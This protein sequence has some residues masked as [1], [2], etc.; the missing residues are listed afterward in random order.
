ME[1]REYKKTLKH[2]NGMRIIALLCDIVRGIISGIV[3]FT[4]K[5][6]STSKTAR[7]ILFVI[8]TVLLFST[9]TIFI[10]VMLIR[11]YKCEGRKCKLIWYAQVNFSMVM[12]TI[13]YF[14]GDN[15]AEI[16]EKW[17][18]A[19]E[20]LLIVGLTGFRFIPKFKEALCKYYEEKEEEDEEDACKEVETFAIRNL[21][22]VPEID[23]WYTAITNI[24]QE[25][26]ANPILNS[27]LWMIF[28]SAVVQIGSIAIAYAAASIKRTDDKVSQCWIRLLAANLIVLT[29]AFLIG[30]N[31]LPLGCIRAVNI[32]P[33]FGLSIFSIILYAL[34]ALILCYIKGKRCC[35]KIAKKPE[36]LRN[37]E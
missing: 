5:D 22:L 23:G 30:D 32:I 4:T 17:R 21:A 31:V 11:D 33:R 16:D 13:S 8:L 10:I 25:C 9:C 24:V 34:P 26:K 18:I 14:V 35:K 2:F 3:K 27:M 15:L 28:G 6:E 19:S 36:D 20:I 7:I 29:I 12:A 1:S 37:D